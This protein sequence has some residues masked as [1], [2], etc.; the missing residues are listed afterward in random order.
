MDTLFKGPDDLK[1]IL[2]E[3]RNEIESNGSDESLNPKESKSLSKLLELIPKDESAGGELKATVQQLNAKI[4]S[5]QEQL[6]TTPRQPVN[7][8][9]NG[10]NL[11]V[12][13]NFDVL[14]KEIEILK[15]ENSHKERLLADVTADGKAKESVLEALQIELKEKEQNWDS[16]KN[17]LSEKIKKME[18]DLENSADE[19]AACGVHLEEFKNLREKLASGDEDEIKEYLNESITALTNVRIELQRQKRVQKLNDH[20]IRSMKAKH[21]DLLAEIATH[22]GRIRQESRQFELIKQNFDFQ[23]NHL[24]SDLENS[25][26]KAQWDQLE[27]KLDEKTKMIRE[28]SEVNSNTKLIQIKMTSLIED[29]EIIE[30]QKNS[31]LEELKTSREKNVKLEELLQKAGIDFDATGSEMSARKKVAILEIAE[32]NQRQKTEHLQR[33]NNELQIAVDTSA[34]R[35]VELE[36]NVKELSTANLEAQEVEQNMRNQLLD[37][38]K[39]EE[40]KQ[41]LAELQH[42]RTKSLE[43]NEELNKYKTLAEL[44]QTQTDRL[45]QGSK[46]K[47][48]VRIL[49]RL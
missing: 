22:R 2:N 31:T 4:D 16:E 33:K 24:R 13:T 45:R 32:L 39:I 11:F 21:E 8:E 5:I 12:L 28:M 29:L 38:V 26:P 34:A 42:L 40:Y 46:D 10:E 49:C 43:D 36:R 41:Q 44:E 14:R 3:L 35:I 47:Q 1:H 23:L 27:A 48:H 20:E 9:T 15:D 30:S 25:V 7:N 17:L 37:S 19:I 18:V 6:T